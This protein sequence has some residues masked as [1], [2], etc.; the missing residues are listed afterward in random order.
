MLSAAI[1]FSSCKKKDEEE[2]NHDHGSTTGSLKLSFDHVV[3]GT[4]LMLNSVN[5]INQNSDTF[6][7][8][9]FQYYISNVK[10]TKTDNSIV[11]LP[12]TY[13]LI[14]TDT[15]VNPSITILGVPV[16]NF[17]KISFMLGVDSTSNVSGAQSGDLDPSFGMFWSWSSGY[18]FYKFEGKSPQSMETNNAITYHIGGFSGVNSAIRNIDVDFGT[19]VLIVEAHRHTPEVMMKV[20]VEEVFKTPT[21]ISINT[22]PKVVMPGV[23]AS[24]LSGNYADM[25]SLHMIH[26]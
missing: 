3:N 1:V 17:K 4:T 14:S 2:D 22:V 5:Y 21:T 16:G 26:N 8:S 7:V 20:H 15:V 13:R 18:I 24:T 6:S 23:N 12:A 25:F 19:Q 9:K 10:L 11:D